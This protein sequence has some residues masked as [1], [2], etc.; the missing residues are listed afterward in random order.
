M[1]RTALIASMMLTGWGLM[2]AQ[3]PVIG[4]VYTP[5]PA[6]YVHGDQV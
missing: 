5:D 6:P 3:N 2:Q 1:N 4:T